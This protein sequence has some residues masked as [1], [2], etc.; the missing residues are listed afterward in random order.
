MMKGKVAINATWDLKM[1]KS[2]NISRRGFIRIISFLIAS[3]IAFAAMAC[4][5]YWQNTRAKW[6][7]EYNYLRSLEH[8]SMSM[9]S[10]KTTLNKGIYSNSPQMMNDLSGKLS[11]DASS[12]KMSLSQLPVSRLNLENTNKFL[13]QVGN[14][15]HSLA[16]RFANGD[17]LTSDDRDNLSKL[18]THAETL[19]DEL[20]DIGSMVSGGHLTFEEVVHHTAEANEDPYPSHIS[21]GFAN[22]EDV[23][24]E[25]PELI[26]DGPFSDHLLKQEPLMLKGEDAVSKETSLQRAREITGLEHLEYSSDQE[27]RIPAY[28]FKDDNATVSFTKDGGF[29]SYMLKYRRIEERSISTERAI[30]IATEYLDKI[31]YENMVHTYYECNGGICT[32]NFAGYRDGVTVYTDL[33]KVGI[34]LDNGEIM[35][36]DARGMITAHHDRNP[37]KPKVS[38]KEAAKNISEHLT[39]K[40]TKTAIIPSTG[41]NERFCYEF[42]CESES[43]SQVLVYI[44][45]DTGVEEKILLLKTSDNGTLV[46]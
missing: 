17:E 1:R 22:V 15:S 39:I 38:K 44:N 46:V 6:H 5:Y 28:T 40:H 12:A 3:V 31:G 4:I 14:Y 30:E 26:Y 41:N 27:G 36:F 43:G 23:F 7:I 24:E 9:D 32:I 18:L 37:G 21:D 34:A 16:R 45:A 10:I 11:H 25:Y 29:F 8:L 42:L 35:S 19:S 20:L 33:I 2:I 13:S